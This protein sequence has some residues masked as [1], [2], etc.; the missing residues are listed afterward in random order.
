MQWPR[1]GSILEAWQ[2]L[3]LQVQVPKTTELMASTHLGFEG[4][5]GWSTRHTFS[6]TP[7]QPLWSPRVTSLPLHCW[8]CF[9]CLWSVL[10][11]LSSVLGHSLWIDVIILQEEGSISPA[12]WHKDQDFAIFLPSH[13]VLLKFVTTLSLFGH[14]R[15]QNK[16]SFSLTLQI[17]II[18]IIIIINY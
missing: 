17:S 1:A 15:N 6:Q 4:G 10:W 3:I 11:P 9:L 7:G 2:L 12:L 16:R 13:K 18:T 14:H 5:R 8:P